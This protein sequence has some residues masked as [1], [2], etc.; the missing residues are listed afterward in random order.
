M[1]WDLLRYF[2]AVAETGTLQRAARRLGVNHSTVF[3]RINRFEEVVGARLFERLRDGYQ[4]TAAGEELLIHARHAGEEIDLLQLKVL[5][6]DFRPSGRIR[7]TAP[8]NLAY[9]Y[10]PTYLMS[11]TKRYPEI[12]LELVVGAENL[13]L[14]QREADI[15]LRATQ[16]P[17]PHLIGRKVLSLKWGYFASQAYLERRG[18]PDDAA[19]L[20]RHE[21]IG[22]DGALQN[23]SPFRLLV[24]EHSANEI[25]MT[26]STLNAMS[27]MAEAGYGIALLPDDQ[28]KPGLVRLFDV[29]P[30]FLSEIWLLTHPELRRTERIRLLMEHLFE[31]FRCDPRFESSNRS[32]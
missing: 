27:A 26:C 8:D 28:V 25:A 7:L 12:M 2:L 24:A 9:E 15:A 19:S 23:V 14:T 32:D 1:D 6:K 13:D 3:R 30:L 10:L 17:P 18:R 5:G 29:E 31:S 11:F 22:A 4:L 20:A 16:S 21:L